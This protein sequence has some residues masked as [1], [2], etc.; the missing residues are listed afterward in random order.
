MGE[1]YANIKYI[2][3]CYEIFGE[4]FPVILVHGF[5]KKEFWMGQIG[6][7]SKEFKVIIFDNRGVGK[8]DSPNEPYTME[9][10]RDDLKALM[11][12]LNIKKAHLIG[13]SEGGMIIQH[14]VLKYPE[15]VDKLV[16]MSTNMGFPDES[17]VELFK[18]NQIALY[19]S[20]LKD[21]IKTFYEKMKMRFSRKFFKEMEQNPEKN[22]Y[23][24]FSANDLLDIDNINPWTPQD[25]L[26]HANA[27]S[28]HNTSDLLYMIKNKTLILTGDKDRLTP[29]I[30]SEQLH[31]KIQGSQLVVIEGGHYFPLEKA[32]EVNKYLLEFLRE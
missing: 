28:T 1:L 11:D 18:N 6:E 20:R 21:P 24:I 4:G 7:L 17:A 10:L 14:F 13:H 5:A 26:N 12:F 9:M 15:M 31:E 27:L 30:A 23:G 22:F 3:I 2:K 29:K 25:I 32:S 16:L 8:S 19:N